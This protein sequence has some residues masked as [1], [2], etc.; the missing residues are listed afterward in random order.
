MLTNEEIKDICQRNDLTRGE[1]YQ[2]RT[3]FAS[4]C[5][6]SDQWVQEQKLASS[7]QTQSDF[8]KTVLSS[9]RDK[10][11]TSQ[12]QP[13]GINVDYFVKYS[14]FLAGSLP[15]IS[16]RILVAQGK[17]FSTIT[18]LGLDVKS[19]NVLV[20]WP[21]FLDLY[22]IFEAGRIDKN[23]MIKFWLRFFDPISTGKCPEKDYLRFLE[24][25]VRGNSLDK[26]NKSTKLFAKLF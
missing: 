2:I 21:V 16:K 18:F 15:H 23:N 17:N 5:L 6:M 3:Q 8:S 1:V 4:M 22:C 7:R 9:Q 25:L 10:K 11:L 12:H 19:P 26:P 20:T 13:E 14:S 24:E